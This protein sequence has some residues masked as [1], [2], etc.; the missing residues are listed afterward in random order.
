MYRISS[1]TYIEDL[2][3][4]GSKQFGGRWNEKGTAM[5]YFAAARAMAV[6]EVLVHVRPEQIA[7]EFVLA[8]FEL[9]DTDIFTVNIEDLP[10]DWKLLEQADELKKIGNRF[11]KGQKYLTMRAPSAI[12]EEEYNILLNPAHPLAKNVKLVDRRPFKFDRRFK[13]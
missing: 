1:P 8:V 5:V 4:A 2:S 13:G 7:K 11:I 12:L 3:G 6:M 10:K 9:P